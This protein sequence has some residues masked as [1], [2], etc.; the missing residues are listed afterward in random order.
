MKAENVLID[1]QGHAK[2]ADF[3][4]SKEGLSYGRVTRTMWHNISHGSGGKFEEM[5]LT[6]LMTMKMTMMMMMTMTM[7]IMILIKSLFTHSYI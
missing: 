2:L 7:T 4:M 6:Q 5:I 3:G 1:M